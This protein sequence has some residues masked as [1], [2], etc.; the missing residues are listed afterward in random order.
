[1]FAL[2]LAGARRLGP[3]F[4]DEIDLDVAAQFYADYTAR[5][6]SPADDRRLPA[7]AAALSAVVRSPD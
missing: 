6:R 7:P 2:A 3:R 5:G 4:V 1:L